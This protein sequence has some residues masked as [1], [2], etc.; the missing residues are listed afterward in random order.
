MKVSLQNDDNQIWIDY[1]EI[2]VLIYDISRKLLRFRLKNDTNTYSFENIS[3]EIFD[4]FVERTN[5]A[6]KSYRI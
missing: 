3:T 5:R 1:D 6:L 2:S 4:D